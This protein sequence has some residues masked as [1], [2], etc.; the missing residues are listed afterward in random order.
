MQTGGPLLH[1]AR[2]TPMQSGGAAR[3]DSRP[4][5][6][7]IKGTTYSLGDAKEASCP[8]HADRG[9]EGAHALPR[10]RGPQCR[11]RG[12]PQDK[13]DCLCSLGDIGGVIMPPRVRGTPPKQQGGCRAP[14]GR[15]LPC[16][17]WGPRG[18]HDPQDR[19]GEHV[20]NLGGVAR[21]GVRASQHKRAPTQTGG[22]VLPKDGGYPHAAWG[23]G[24]Q[25]KKPT[26]PQDKGVPHGAWGVSQTTSMQTEEPLNPTPEYGEWGERPLF[27]SRIQA[28]VPLRPPNPALSPAPGGGL[29]GGG[30]GTAIGARP[31]RS[32]ATGIFAA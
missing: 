20:S 10:T 15:G 19:G 32:W 29:R 25:R 3:E 23:E 2:G 12:P 11:L 18:G 8:P 27:P 24:M 21:G 6:P 17:L 26:T 7:K 22:A 1:K 4:P 30:R 14:G 13:G 5:P 9:V 31:W 28:R 16:T